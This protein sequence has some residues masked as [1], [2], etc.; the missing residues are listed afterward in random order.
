MPPRLQG[1][2]EAFR[3]LV[4]K[5]VLTKGRCLNQSDKAIEN[6]R[7]TLY[8]LEMLHLVLWDFTL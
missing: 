3:G 8:L 4:S 5:H 1:S 2:A 6:P 7:F